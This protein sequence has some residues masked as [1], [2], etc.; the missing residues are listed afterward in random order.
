MF[1]FFII[2]KLGKKKLVKVKIN[3]LCIH[4]SKSKRKVNFPQ[5]TT[6]GVQYTFSA[7]DYN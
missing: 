4:I 3:I 5:P 1:I 6:N 2:L 7:D